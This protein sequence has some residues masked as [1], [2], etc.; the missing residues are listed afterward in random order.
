MVKN[1]HVVLY[2]QSLI[3]P[4]YYMH[5]VAVAVLDPLSCRLKNYYFC[6]CAL[7]NRRELLVNFRICSDK[8]IYVSY[9]MRIVP[10]ILLVVDDTI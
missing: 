2:L 8:S 10:V 6:R 7:I 9:I 5:T 3:N 4:K 1:F